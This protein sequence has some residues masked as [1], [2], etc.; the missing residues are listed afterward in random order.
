MLEEPVTNEASG[1]SSWKHDGNDEAV[2]HET[3][4]FCF[5]FFKSVAFLSL[6]SEIVYT[7]ALKADILN[8]FTLKWL[9]QKLR[10]WL[11]MLFTCV[12]KPKRIEQV[13]FQEIPVYLWTETEAFPLSNRK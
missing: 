4:F 3:L 11:K 6:F 1:N 13:G 10:K 12:P 9:F 2:K 8:F 7:K 5:F